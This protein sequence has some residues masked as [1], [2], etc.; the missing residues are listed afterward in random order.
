M[1]KFGILFCGYNMEEY[2]HQSLAPW[3]EAKNSNLL[4]Y[5]FI[6]SAVCLP[7]KEYKDQ[8]I[9]VDDTLDILIAY[10]D[11]NHIQ[12]LFSEPKYCSEADARN[13]ALKP[14]LD[15][16]CDMIILWDADEIATLENIENI[17]K[18][19]ELEKFISW[20]RFSYKNYVFDDKTYLAAP[21]TPPRLF[22]VNTNGYKLINFHWDNDITYQSE[23][24]SIKEYQHSLPSKTIPAKTAFI[25]HLSWISNEK[26][27]QKVNYQMAHFNGV[28]SFAWDDKEN[29]LVWNKEYFAKTGQPIP[30]VIRET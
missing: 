21:F 11:F 19:V 1:S 17:L 22:R 25:K 24:C 26:S 20:F 8:D 23:D 3:V 14:L 30:E 9:K 2:I 13:L 10:R 4:G 28:C 6:I 29:K 18:Y 5:E 16:G 12:Y 27:K 15:Q 7:F